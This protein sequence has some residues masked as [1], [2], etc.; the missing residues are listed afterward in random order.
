MIIKALMGLDNYKPIIT[1]ARHA[2]TEDIDRTIHNQTLLILSI[3]NL[4]SY[5]N[6]KCRSIELVFKWT[7][8]NLQGCH[9]GL[10]IYWP[11][12][13][14]QLSVSVKVRIDKISTISYR[15]WPHIAYILVIFPW[16]IN[17]TPIYWQFLEYRVSV[18][19]NSEPIKYQ[20]SAI[21]FGQI[22]VIGYRLNLT[23]IPPQF[24][25]HLLSPLLLQVNEYS[26]NN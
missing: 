17:K 26:D 24:V 14:Y 21:G 13:E 20:L 3:I 18:L 25:I 23:R 5:T 8:L 7:S 19:V 12:W 10:P 9:I 2:Q 15:L 22:S 16:Y 1:Q 11:F 6:E 4:W